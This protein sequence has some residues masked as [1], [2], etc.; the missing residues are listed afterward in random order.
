[1]KIPPKV[2]SEFFTGFIT[3]QGER[4][5]GSRFKCSE[6]TENLSAVI[7]AQAGLNR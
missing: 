3:V 6:F 7:P 2:V 1:M 4:F 5:G